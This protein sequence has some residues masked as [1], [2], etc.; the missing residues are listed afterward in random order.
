[1]IYTDKEQAQL[2][3]DLMTRKAPSGG[4]WIPVRI[5]HTFGEHTRSPYQDEAWQP[6]RVDTPEQRTRRMMYINT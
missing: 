1:M 6:Q 2:E 5:V 3:C 4:L